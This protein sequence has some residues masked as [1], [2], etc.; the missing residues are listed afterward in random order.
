[1]GPSSPFSD[2]GGILKGYLEIGR[3]R[4]P[5]PDLPVK[6]REGV[7]TGDELERIASFIE[8]WE[9]EDPSI[10]V[11]TSGSTGERKAIG[12]SKEGMRAS[13]RMTRDHY[14]IPDES[15]ALL[16]LSTAYIAGKMMLVRAMEGNWTLRFLEASRDPVSEMDDGEC[17]AFAAMVPM[18]VQEALK[19]QEKKRTFEGIEKLIIGGAPVPAPLEKRI[20]TVRTTCFATY[21]M[22]ETITHIA[23]RPLNGADA[24]DRYRPMEGVEV[25][26]DARGC[27]MVRAPHLFEGTVRTND[28]IEL[29]EEGCFKVR[30]RFDRLINSGAVKLLPEE[31][32]RKLEPVMDRRFF[33]HKEPDEELGERAVLLLEGPPLDET[34]ERLLFSHMEEVLDPYEVPKRIGTVAAFAET[35]S[36]KVDRRRTWNKGL[37]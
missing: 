4:F 17:F 1:M 29:D 9:N 16:C 35:G 23:D 8:E 7:L 37:S 11:L 25:G 27:L 34:T 22:T 15:H 36:G 12:L 13:A 33:I 19:D 3:E 31:L 2:A 6:L 14:R 21:G 18:Q 30:G 28:L 32:E 10:E 20:R 26:S 24:S 5:I